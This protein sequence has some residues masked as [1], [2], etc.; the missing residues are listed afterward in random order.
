MA[1]SKILLL[2]P[3]EHLGSEGDE[4]QV[5]AGYAR[6]WLFPRRKAI[7]V[8]ESNRKQVEALKM[9]RE[10]RETKELESAQ[11]LK[12]KIEKVRLAFALKTADGGK[13]L[14]GSIT[15]QNIIDR[16]NEEGIVLL[17]KQIHLHG[18]VKSLGKNVVAVKLH[19]DVTVD[20]NFE[21][22][23][24]NPIEESDQD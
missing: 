2:E 23:S 22:V 7:P 16:L 14:F 3:V 6:N 18:P 10:K 8:N 24:E 12:A 9:R 5:A 20:L 19:K 21:V 11:G 4:V 15:V 17:K 1:K 13:R